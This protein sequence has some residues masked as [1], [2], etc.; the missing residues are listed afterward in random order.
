MYSG[1]TTSVRVNG[2]LSEDY[3][4]HGSTS[5]ICLEPTPVLSPLLFTVVLEMLSSNFR[6]NLLWELLY[7]DDLILITDSMEEAVVKF[8]N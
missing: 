1:S 2:V 8:K 5:G 7:G 6:N 4:K 3:S